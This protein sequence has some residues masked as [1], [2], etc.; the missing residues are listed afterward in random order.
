M[1]NKNN[2]HTMYECHRKNTDN[3]V[4][5]QRR[6]VGHRNGGV[7]VLTVFTFIIVVIALGILFLRYYRPDVDRIPGFDTGNNVFKD[8][9][10]VDSENSENGNSGSSS[11]YKRRDGVYNFLFIAKDHV[12]ENTD[13]IMVISF[14]TVNSD[15]SVLQI[16]RDTFIEYNNS[17]RRINYL[18]SSL[19]SEAQNAGEKNSVNVALEK[20]S[21]IVEK[22]M[23]IEIDYHI[24]IDLEGFASIVD[25]IGGVEMDV[26]YDLNYSD[27]DQGL[28]INISKGHQVLDGNKAEQFVRF[29]SDFV[30]GDIGRVDA[31]KIFIS[32]FLRQLKESFSLKTIPALVGSVFN[33][34]VDTNISL[35]DAV[36]FAKNVLS[37]ELENASFVTLPGCSARANIDS[38]AWYY[39]MSR[40]DTLKVINEYVNV[41]D[42]DIESHLFDRYHVFSSGD[43]HIDE[44]YLAEEG[45][46]YRNAYNAED[47]NNSPPVIPGSKQ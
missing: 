44:I 7:I 31:Q 21:E 37:V 12:A 19:H 10:T 36:F 35:A 1:Q 3:N 14:D 17:G 34:L 25:A 43:P 23:C 32:A 13:V 24:L 4:R 18:Y 42:K 39:I 6:S 47:I 41:Y 46:Y 20:L 28:Y 22:N 26:P 30:E 29:R 8:T 9:E 27:P 5:H 33:C 40:T 11:Q 38:G 16:P 15:L 45:K 2:K